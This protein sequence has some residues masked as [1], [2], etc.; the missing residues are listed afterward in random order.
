MSNPNDLP[1][2]WFQKLQFEKMSTDKNMAK[3]H[4]L[5]M[6]Y[7]DLHQCIVNE[8]NELTEAIITGGLVSAIGECVDIANFAAMLAHKI[9]IENGGTC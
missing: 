5:N 6:T 7:Y 9:H 2:A 8:L 4:W 1:L 3:T